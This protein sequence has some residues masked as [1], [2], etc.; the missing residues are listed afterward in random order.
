MHDSSIAC[1]YTQTCKAD[2]LAT[3]FYVIDY[4]S[5]ARLIKVRY[6]MFSCLLV[7]LELS[8]LMTIAALKGNQCLMSTCYSM[9]ITEALYLSMVVKIVTEISIEIE[10]D[11]CHKVLYII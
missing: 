5:V 6:I 11:K 8:L 1:Q 10:R 7:Q 2:R 9:A 4:V 3:K